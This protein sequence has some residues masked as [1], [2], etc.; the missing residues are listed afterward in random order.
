M[1]LPLLPAPRRVTLTGL[2]LDLSSLPFLEGIQPESVEPWGEEAYRLEIGPEGIRLYAHSEAGL[3]WGRATLAQLRTLSPV[4]AL[5]IDDAPLFPHRGVMLDISRDRVPT[6]ESLFALVDH[7]AAWKMNHLQLYVEHTIAYAGHEAVWG[8]ASPISLEEL[9][10]LDQY[11]VERG[12]ALNANQNSLGHFERWLCHPHYAPLGERMDG[13]IIQNI[14]YSRP[15]TL[16]PLDSRVMPLLEDLLGQQLPRCSGAYANIGCDEPWDLGQ[17]RSAEACRERGKS[18][19]FSEHVNAVAERVRKLGKIPQFWCDPEPHED[20]S[21]TRDLV[22]L[23][24]GYEEQDDFKKRAKAHHKVGRGV[25]VAPG[26]SCWNSFTGRSWNRRANLNNAAAVR[27]ADG[28]LCTAWGDG[29][30]PQAWP[31]TLAGFADAAMA[32]WSGPARYDDHALGLHVFGEAET[33]NWIYRLGAVDEELS[34]GWR[35][36]RCGE[37]QPP[38][39]NASAVWREFN[40]PFHDPAGPGDTSAWEEI[41]LRLARLEGDFLPGGNARMGR[42]CQLMLS[43]ARWTAERA[44]MR[45]RSCSMEDRDVLAQQMVGLVEEYRSQWLDRSRYGGLERSLQRLITHLVS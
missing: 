41:V 23:V 17:G 45:R 2:E 27:E 19:V 42:E 39:F 1:H 7:L 43:L 37:A 13:S 31:V 4:P 28:F 18:R 10:L 21:L 30:H 24:W 3:R 35:R 38:I 34:R 11:C 40:T 44:L 36:A 8:H 32:A 16:C 14:R 5:Q 22:A 33:G 6:M 26:T 25:W 12:V 15:N 29:G 9:L 20:D